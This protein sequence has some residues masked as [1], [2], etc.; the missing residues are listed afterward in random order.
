MWRT[1]IDFTNLNKACPKDNFLLPRID[2]LVDATERHKLLSFMDAYSK[3]NHILMYKPDEE[4]NSFITDQGLYYYK[5]IPFD[6][7]NAGETYQRL[8]NGMFK[9]LIVKSM[10]V[11]VDDILVKSKT[12]GDHI[13]HLNWM[14]NILRKYQLKLNPLKCAFG[15]SSS[16]CLGVMVNQRGIEANS[17]KINVLL[18][19]SSPRKPKEVMS[20]ANRVAT[21]SHFVL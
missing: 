10:E 8:M 1:C 19:M 6:L 11:Y 3:Y 12:V 18:E 17:K 7:K 5:A 4:H 21:L 16:K 20:L 9:Y 15:V 2:Q 14:F 13:E